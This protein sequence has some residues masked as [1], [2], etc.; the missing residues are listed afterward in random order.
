[1]NAPLRTSS[2]CLP[3]R[4]GLRPRAPVARSV[5]KPHAPRDPAGASARLCVTQGAAVSAFQPGTRGTCVGKTP[6]AQRS[7]CSAA[8][9]YV[10]RG[11]AV[12]AFSVGTLGIC[13]GKPHAP[14]QASA[15]SV[16]RSLDYWGVSRC[17]YGVPRRK[18]EPL[19]FARLRANT[20]KLPKKLA[21]V[22]PVAFVWFGAGPIPPADH[23]PVSES[24]SAHRDF[25]RV[26]GAI[27]GK[28]P[29][30]PEN[31][32]VHPPAYASPRIRQS[33]FPTGTRGICVGKTP[34]AQRSR[35]RIRL[36][37]RHQGFDCPRSRPASE[38]F[39]W[40][41]PHA[42]R[43]A[44]RASAGLCITQGSTVSTFPTGT[45][46][47]CVGKTPYAQR[48]RRRIRP[49]LRHPGFNGVRNHDRHAR[50]MRE[51]TPCAQRPPRS[52]TQSQSPRGFANIRLPV[53][54]KAFMARSRAGVVG[55]DLRTVSRS[56]EMGEAK[57][58]QTAFG[59]TFG[60]RTVR[61]SLPWDCGCPWNCSH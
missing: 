27:G 28:D 11:S 39:A 38:A 12:S 37:M 42:P 2:C 5:G 8:C 9:L 58:M 40:E 15:G 47:I 10:T 23:P 53:P 19:P 45:G 22:T 61:S 13:V 33:P 29:I 1:M 54:A 32:S 60:I 49:P 6:C 3:Q 17:L 7:L 41:R 31:L 50:H 46:G 20:V 25:R 14:R 4:P 48:R 43:E 51:M 18:V 35:R 30:R 16:A 57:A 26:R 34:C 59:A 24:G 52:P 21:V 36:P 55:S 56:P 44:V